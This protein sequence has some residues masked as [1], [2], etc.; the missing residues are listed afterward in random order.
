[1]RL[2]LN[3]LLFEPGESS[4]RVDSR[5]TSRVIPLHGSTALWP[6][7]ISPASGRD[8]RV[9][10]EGERSVEPPTNHGCFLAIA[11]STLPEESLPAIPFASG[12]NIG[13]SESQPCGGS[14]R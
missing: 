2:F 11:F 8:S 5:S 1:M 9:L 7:V 10:V 6:R 3:A 14:R 12:G 4:E 13:I